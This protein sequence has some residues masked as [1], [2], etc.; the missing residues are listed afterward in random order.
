MALLL[1]LEENKALVLT[2]DRHK[3]LEDLTADEQIG[4]LEDGQG[5]IMV[6]T[7]INILNKLECS[8]LCKPNYE[9]GGTTITFGGPREIR[10]SQRKNKNLPYLNSS[11]GL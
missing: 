6:S 1:R 10:V 5:F 9:E 11:S 4:R 8:I 2:V 7:L 3:I